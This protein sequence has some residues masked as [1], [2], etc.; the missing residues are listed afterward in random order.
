MSR[1]LHFPDNRL[2]DGGE[3]VSLTSQP[4]ALY[5]Q[6]NSWYS[7]LLEVEST[8]GHI[9][10]GRIRSIEKSNDPSRIEPVIFRL[11]TQC[12]NQLHYRVLPFSSFLEGG[13][14]LS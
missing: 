11:V 6:E 4:A 9:A 8:P 10:A 1:I 14:L 3:V 12:L 2:T 13:K 7:F 5:T